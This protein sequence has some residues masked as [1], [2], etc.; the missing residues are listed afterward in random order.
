M[1]Q[2]PRRAGLRGENGASEHGGVTF[3]EEC[4][5]DGRPSTA[6]LLTPPGDWVP[7]RAPI[8]LRVTKKE[9]N[10]TENASTDSFVPDDRTR[11]AALERRVEEKK[12][13]KDSDWLVS[14]RQLILSAGV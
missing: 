8:L 14:P 12:K 6:S 7:V 9:K 2:L 3:R 10:K 1:E 5:F 11:I 4:D 13:T